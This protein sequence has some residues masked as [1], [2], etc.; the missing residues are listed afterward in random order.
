[1]S[2]VDGFVLAVPAANKERF[3]AM[4]QRIAEA[5]TDHG[6]LRVVENWADDVPAGERTWFARAVDLQK[7]EIVCFSWVEWPSREARDKGNAAIAADP[8]V[9][10]RADEADIMDAKRMIYG[11]FTTLVDRRG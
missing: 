8:R 9:Q 7:G 3:R 1:M 5:F 4:A 6:A 10:P 2:Y 11:G